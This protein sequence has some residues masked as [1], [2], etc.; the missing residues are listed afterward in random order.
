MAK[1]TTTCFSNFPCGFAFVWTSAL[2]QKQDTMRKFIPRICEKCSSFS[3]TLMANHLSK[4]FLS[5][6]LATFCPTRLANG[7]ISRSTRRWSMRHRIC[8]HQ[9]KH[10]PLS[11]NAVH[12]SERADNN[13]LVA[14]INDFVSNADSTVMAVLLWFADDS[15]VQEYVT[16]CEGLYKN[17]QCVKQLGSCYL[18]LVGVLKEDLP[19]HVAAGILEYEWKKIVPDG[20]LNDFQ[21]FT[22]PNR[23][24]SK[25]LNEIQEIA[26]QQLQNLQTDDSAAP[27]DFEDL[28]TE[29]IFAVDWHREREELFLEFVGTKDTDDLRVK[30]AKKV[31]EMVQF[32]V[33]QEGDAREWVVAQMESFFSLLEAETAVSPVVHTEE[34]SLMPEE[35]E[36]SPT[37]VTR[38]FWGIHLK[39]KPAQASQPLN[40]DLLHY[41]IANGYSYRRLGPVGADVRASKLYIKKFTCANPEMQVKNDFLD[42]PDH[43]FFEA[44]I[45]QLAP[46]HAY[47]PGTFSN[48]F[49]GQD[50]ELDE[51]EDA[52]EAAAK[53][54]KDQAAV[55]PGE[56]ESAPAATRD[57]APQ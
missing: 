42:F 12:P 40:Q 5:W 50:Q 47:F 38:Q 27:E 56:A 7:L 16:A 43:Q 28:Y 30:F 52:V 41:M 45:F 10:P 11:S 6:N 29:F 48:L 54:A 34:T 15:P 37:E 18:S 8:P 3:L 22:I 55:A 13:T 17:V 21:A 24:L 53:A 51:C 19:T 25:I 2:L 31:G 44:F 35:K 9:R 32:Q 57:T 46:A 26:V 23:P 14:A 1:T 20:H 36:H 39:P 33:P 4:N 49:G